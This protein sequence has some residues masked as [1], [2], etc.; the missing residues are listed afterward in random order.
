MLKRLL[1][2]TFVVTLMVGTAPTSWI[3]QH[4][5]VAYAEKCACKQGCKCDHCSGKS[6]DCPCPKY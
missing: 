6:K 5:G 2:A 3:S 1:I 4:S